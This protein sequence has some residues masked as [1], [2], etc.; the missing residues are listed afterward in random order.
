MEA[1]RYFLNVVLFTSIFHIATPD[2][3]VEKTLPPDNKD[4]ESETRNETIFFQKC[5]KD[6][7]LFDIIDGKCNHLNNGTY[8]SLIPKEVRMSLGK[9]LHIF[10]IKCLP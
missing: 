1:H 5:C 2:K 7:E 6:T 9:C 10:N 8:D 3:I 4:N